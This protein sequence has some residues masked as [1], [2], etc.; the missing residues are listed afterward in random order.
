VAAYTQILAWSRTRP[1]WQ[2]DALRRLVREPWTPADTERVVAAV[3]A[4][5]GLGAELL[6]PLIA[7]S[8]DHLPKQGHAAGPVSLLGLRDVADIGVLAPGEK[9]PF[10]R[11]GLTAVYGENGSG[12]T[13]YSRVL[14]CACRARGA[15]P[16]VLPSVYAKAP[17][18]PKAIVEYAV[19]DTPREATWTSAAPLPAE[20]SQVAV[21]D[22]AVA[23]AYLTSKQDVVL[24]PAGLDLLRRLVDGCGVVRERLQAELVA[25]ERGTQAPLSFPP[26]T[27]VSA[28]KQQLSA[29]TRDQDIDQLAIVTLEDE[30]TLRKLREELAKLRAQDPVAWARKASA[31]AARMV[32]LRR[33]LE[34]ICVA[35]GDGAAGRF[36]SAAERFQQATNAAK[37]AADLAAGRDPL[38]GVGSGDWRVMWEAAREY[39]VRHAYAGKAFPVIDDARCVLCQQELAEEGRERLV[40]FDELVRNAASAAAESAGQEL[41]DAVSAIERLDLS[42]EDG[43]ALLSELGREDLRTT[44]EAFLAAAKARRRDWAANSDG[45]YPSDPC[46]PYGDAALAGLQADLEQASIVRPDAEMT[47]RRGELGRQAAELEARAELAR[48]K[49]EVVV[50]LAALRRQDLLRKCIADTDSASITRK[51]GE[52]TKTAVTDELRAAFADEIDAL[53]LGQHHVEL[54]TAGASKGSL[55]H[56]LGLRDT[57][58]AAAP[59]VVLSEG[60][61]NASA[62]AM[63]FAEIRLDE[64]GSAVV[65]DDPVSSLDHVRRDT[66]ARRL[67]VEAQRRQVIVFTHDV[68]FLLALQEAAK[69]VGMELTYVHV[70]RSSEDA[71]RCSEGL[72]WIGQ[73][74]KTRI[75]SLNKRWQELDALHRKN[76]D[77]Y[78]DGA[79]ACYGLLRETWERA[80]EEILFGGVVERFRL[81]IQTKQLATVDVTAEDRVIVNR[82]M[83]K[84]SRFLQGHDQ[85]AAVNTPVPA[86]GELRKDIAELDGWVAAVDARRKL[87]KKAPTVLHLVDPNVAAATKPPA[88][89]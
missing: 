58:A 86:P 43:L 14:K 66:V 50:R 54:R 77:L 46:L 62:L 42:A 63:F 52:L 1:L 70:Q 80:I 17:G 25:E 71:G 10:A 19:A 18:T 5:R 48:R 75:G 85:P 13:S 68:V 31:Q 83:T 8:E 69:D 40:R 3:K 76:P 27:K 36:R 4:A 33:K 34:G 21:F 28:L 73:K 88:V 9:L 30:A 55:Y 12:K 67:V 26:G 45:S 72:P 11:T 65:F 79:R 74:V 64:S 23:S 49:G 51:S 37:L 24:A 82:A 29:N 56:Q 20:L 39:S 81:A 47:A 53:G 16:E 59:A 7:L 32:A 44:V 61:K 78:A 89:S 87:A 35:L 15:R 60:E 41:H 84:T 38:P 2:Q 22:A 6:E 57:Q